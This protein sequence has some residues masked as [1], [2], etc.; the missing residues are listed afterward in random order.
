M[1]LPHAMVRPAQEWMEE[2]A[3]CSNVI[4]TSRARYA[5]NVDG[6]PFAPHASTRI[7]GQV[8]DDIVEALSRNHFFHEYFHLDM[9]EVSG[10]E[11]AYLK[12]SRLIS[13]EME[14]GGANRAVYVSTDLKSSIMVNEEDHL[15]IQTLEPGLQINKVQERLAQLEEEIADVISFARHERFGYLT[16]CPTNVGTGIR[17]SVMMHLPG[18]ALNHSIEGRLKELPRHGFAIRGFHGENSENLGDFYQISNEIT[19]GRSV[20]QLEE[21]IADLVSN[22]MDA[23]LEARSLLHRKGGIVVED[24]VWRSYGIL[25]TARKMDSAEAMKLLSRIRLGIDE[26]YFPQLTHEKLNKLIVESQPGHLIIKHGAPEDAEQRDVA[27]AEL[28]RRTLAAWT[29]F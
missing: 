26:G 4:V 28:I 16:A 7:L 22:L 29:Q 8:R 21:K 13:K 5:R 12:E 1:S 14:R 20:R 9:T 15:R 25:A 11:R 10:I 6:A 18:L 3:P 27:R 23:E 24:S 19:L 2:P 17:V